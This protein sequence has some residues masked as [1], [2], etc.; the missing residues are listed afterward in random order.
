MK[1]LLDKMVKQGTDNKSGQP[2]VAKKNEIQ[3]FLEKVSSMP[4]GPVVTG[5]EARLVF[6]LDATASRQFTWGEVIQQLRIS[7]ATVSQILKYVYP[8]CAKL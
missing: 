4:K 3:T 1:N 5:K 7:S 8:E 6:S 2:V